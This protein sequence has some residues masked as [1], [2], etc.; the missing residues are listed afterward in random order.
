M[1]SPEMTKP[2]PGEVAEAKRHP[3]GW[4]YRIAGKF[5]DNERIP[6]EAVVGAW[7]VDANGNIIGSFVPNENY[8]AKK[9]PS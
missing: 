6:A 9:W 7:Q 4:V 8:D 5:H 3:N 1:P 2:S